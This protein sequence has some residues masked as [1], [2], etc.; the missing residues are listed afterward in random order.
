MRVAVNNLRQA[1]ESIKHNTEQ[2]M[3]CADG[4]KA[5][6]ESREAYWQS[7]INSASTESCRES[8]AAVTAQRDETRKLLKRIVDWFAYVR[9]PLRDNWTDENL[10][11]DIR[12]FL[13]EPEP[14]PEPSIEQRVAALEEWLEGNSLDARPLHA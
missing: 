10:L 1:L 11:A 9:F 12:A 7:Q 6:D 14:P 4:L 13:R 3:L 2:A 5:E 8:L